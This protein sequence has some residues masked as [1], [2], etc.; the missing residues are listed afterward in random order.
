MSHFQFL[1][2]VEEKQRTT[3]PY[4]R[5]NPATYLSRVLYQPRM[6]QRRLGVFYKRDQRELVNSWLSNK[7]GWFVKSCM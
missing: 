6:D 7:G 3:T 1:Q 5:R 2:K 4:R